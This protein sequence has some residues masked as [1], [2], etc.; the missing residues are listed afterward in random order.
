MNKNI[1]RGLKVI[2][3]ILF[4]FVFVSVYNV[5]QDSTKKFEEV[6]SQTQKDLDLSVMVQQDNQM[7]RRNLGLDPES[8]EQI[9]YYKI[10]DV[11]QANE[12][13]L[14]QFK[15]HS[16]QKPFEESI[17]KRI[18]DQINLYEGY[19]PDQVQLLDKA[20]VNVQANY[21][22]YAVDTNASSLEVQF[23]SSL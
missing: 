10:D 22:L 12:Y 13:V 8:Y 1:L 5:P 23:L 17:Q 16:Q 2:V 7:I 4:V 14:V 20:V 15:D 6:L 9:V 11:M 19:A 21:A 18:D 3:L